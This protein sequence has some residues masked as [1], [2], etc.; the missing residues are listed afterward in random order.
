MYFKKRQTFSVVKAIRSHWLYLFWTHERCLQ[1]K[2]HIANDIENHK[3][4]LE[5]FL[6]RQIKDNGIPLTKCFRDLRTSRD[7]SWRASRDNV[8]FFSKELWI[9]FANER[10]PKNPWSF[11][12]HDFYFFQSGM[13]RPLAYHNQSA[14]NNHDQLF[15]KFTQS[16]KFKYEFSLIKFN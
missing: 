13:Y 16:T 5:N 3:I 8:N 12:V 2:S 4:G 15:Q 9:C 14:P 11:I 10:I 1:L 6:G 7:I